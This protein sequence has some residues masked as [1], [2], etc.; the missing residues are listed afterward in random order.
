MYYGE[1]VLIV[2]SK[3]HRVGLEECCGILLYDRAPVEA[4]EI[5]LAEDCRDYSRYF[6]C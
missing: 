5:L 1:F 6:G 2:Q 3:Y 4:F